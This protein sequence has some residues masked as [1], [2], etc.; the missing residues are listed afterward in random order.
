MEFMPGFVLLT[1]TQTS[2][3]FQDWMFACDYQ[4]TPSVVMWFGP[5]VSRIL[6]I[7]NFAFI[8]L[9]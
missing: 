1:V 7:R 8:V 6:H 9:T 4:V 5:K 2:H 3:T